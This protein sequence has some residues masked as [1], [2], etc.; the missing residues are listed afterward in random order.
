MEIL[1]INPD[2]VWAERIAARLRAIG[3]R[4]SVAENWR[5]A[6]AMLDQA[7]P[8]IVILEDRIL[9]HEAAAMVAALRRGDRLPLMVPTDFAPLGADPVRVT[10]RGE[11]ALRRLESLV[12]RLQG[13]FTSAAQQAI[14][15]GKLTIDTARKEVVFG[16]RRVPLPPHQFNLL[17][18]LALNV[19]RVVEQRELVREVWGY[20][21][22]DNEARE[23]VKAHVRQI[24]RKLGWTDETDSYLHS[25]RGFGYMLSP[26]ERDKRQPK[27]SPPA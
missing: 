25:V 8:N 13:A 12:M 2:S 9:E 20:A 17:L 22:S 7:W 24:R 21:G 27:K 1:L 16:A 4:V 10:L 5:S 23:L 26:P 3:A 19:G 15:V 6:E 14:R 18:Y 11:D